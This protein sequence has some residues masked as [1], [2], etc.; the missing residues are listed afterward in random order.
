MI[1]PHDNVAAFERLVDKLR[2][3]N[4]A[5]WKLAYLTLFKNDFAKEWE[6]ITSEMDFKNVS[7]E[8]MV[9]AIQKTAKATLKHCC[10]S[11]ILAKLKL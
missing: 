9:A 8:E 5:E 4:D 3:R 11:N 2:N 10:K 1:S 6:N 7:D